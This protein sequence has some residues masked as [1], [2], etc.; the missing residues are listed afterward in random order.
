[1]ADKVK[2]EERTIQ[3]GAEHAPF[4]ATPGKDVPEHV[5][6]DPEHHTD[7]RTRR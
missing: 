2:Q 1:M 4:L 3:V 7:G 6:A 5:C